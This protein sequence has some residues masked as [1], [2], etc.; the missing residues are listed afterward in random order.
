LGGEVK[1][2]STG[3]SPK[4]IMV[5]LSVP[6]IADEDLKHLKSLPSLQELY[7]LAPT[8]KPINITDK[9]LDYI[10]ELSNLRELHIVR[11]YITD[12][13]LEKLH[14]LRNLRILGLQNV[15]VSA[16]GL[17]KLQKALPNLHIGN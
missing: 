16:E 3:K 13:G 5:N 7:L 6:N 8:N 11:A 15:N 9:G 2:E 4:V 17:N 10:K 12:A 1:L 14:G